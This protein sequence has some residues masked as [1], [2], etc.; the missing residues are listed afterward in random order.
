MKRDEAIRQLQSIK[1]Q[2]LQG[3]Q[4]LRLLVSRPLML[5]FETEPRS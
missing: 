2:G 3:I 4:V 1:S 5:R